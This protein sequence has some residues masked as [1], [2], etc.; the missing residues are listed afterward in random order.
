MNIWMLSPIQNGKYTGHCCSWGHRVYIWERKRSIKQDFLFNCLGE[1]K[2]PMKGGP[3]MENHG[4]IMKVPHT[5]WRTAE[6][7]RQI[8]P[9]HSADDSWYL[10]E[11]FLALWG[12]RSLIYG[13][14]VVSY[15]KMCYWNDSGLSN[16]DLGRRSR[17]I[18]GCFGVEVV[19]L[20]EM[21]LGNVDKQHCDDCDSGWLTQPLTL[22]P[23]WY[24]FRIF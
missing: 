6:M 15:M 16:F 9:F 3:W 23:Y 4:W 18:F 14:E 2:Q 22:F 7:C 24:L 20:Q 17:I 1:K 19:L 11:E 10:D 21:E 13:M 5:P 12:Y 8:T